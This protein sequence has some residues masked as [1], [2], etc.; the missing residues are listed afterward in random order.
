MPTFQLESIRISRLSF[1]LRGH[2][3]QIS[4]I[5]RRISSL[6]LASSFLPVEKRGR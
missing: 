6:F 3:P 1:L 4:T 5:L 2:S